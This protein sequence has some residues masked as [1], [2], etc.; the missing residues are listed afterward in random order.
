MTDTD[1]IVLI[2]W[3]IA[4]AVLI[5]ICVRI[6]ISSGRPVSPRLPAGRAQAAGMKPAGD[7][8]PAPPGRAP[9]PDRRQ[10][11]AA[12]SHGELLLG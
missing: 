9:G 8:D 12:L 5:L 1:L 6:H 4:G 7:Q 10:D 3:A 2:P 11:A